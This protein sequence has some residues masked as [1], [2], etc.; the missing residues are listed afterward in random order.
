MTEK[1]AELLEKKEFMSVASSDL[2]CEPNAAPKFLIKVKDDCIFLADY[3][4]GK[5]YR[6]LKVNPKVS[7]STVDLDTL[8]GYQI[9]GTA[10]I[11][12]HGPEYD[13]LCDA[14]KEKKIRHTVQ[15]FIES[16]RG[17]KNYEKFETALPDK[18]VVFK[19]T[20]RAVVKIGASGE[21]E[22][23]GK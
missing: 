10:E 17:V 14:M 13:G 23:R 6:N 2:R 22:R 20:C 15:R 5:T 21:L 4:M 18:I 3:V 19:I 8:E 7:V 12:D 16:V 11:L 1:M 9:N